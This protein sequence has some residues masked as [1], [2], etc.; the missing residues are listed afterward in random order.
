MRRGSALTAG[1]R[2]LSHKSPGNRAASRSPRIRGR[3]CKAYAGEGSSSC[4]PQCPPH[5]LLVLDL[6]NGAL[7]KAVMRLAIGARAHHLTAAY[8]AG[9]RRGFPKREFAHVLMRR[10]K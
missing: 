4:C 2:P 3:D 8:L 10:K 7:S 9:F 1:S 6:D 5:Q